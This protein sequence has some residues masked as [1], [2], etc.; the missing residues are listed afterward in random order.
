MS[1]IVIWALFSPNAFGQVS[2]SPKL[3]GRLIRICYF[4]FGHYLESQLSF[5]QLSFSPKVMAL[6]DLNLLFF[7]WAL[8]S[9]PNVVWPSVILPKVVAP[10]DPS[11][12]F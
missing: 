5:G 3:C 9:M 12:L 6:T 11:L 10:N 8:F 1:F 4:L 2:F 7:I